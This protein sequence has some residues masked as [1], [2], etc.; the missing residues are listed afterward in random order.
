MVLTYFE[1]LP[2][3]QTEY[4]FSSL[5]ENSFRQL[6]LSLREVTLTPGDLL[7]PPAQ[8][9]PSI[10]I[11][12]SGEIELFLSFGGKEKGFCKISKGGV[13]REKGF[14]TG[15]G[16]EEGGRS[17]GFSKVMEVDR[18]KFLEIIKNN[19]RDFERFCAAKEN[20]VFATKMVLTDQRC[21]GCGEGG[22]LV[23][24]CK[25][26]SLNIRK[27][28]VIARHCWDSGQKRTVWGRKRKKLNCLKMRKKCRDGVKDLRGE[29]FSEEEEEEQEQEQEDEEEEFEES[30]EEKQNLKKLEKINSIENSREYRILNNQGSFSN[31]R[32]FSKEIDREKPK[33]RSMIFSPWN[34]QS[35]GTIAMLPL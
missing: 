6:T 18:D 20:T 17:L 26:S 10:Y 11:I 3:A 14:I 22:H 35:S 9:S 23:W 33:G 29:L 25:W 24:E 8:A 30:I 7:F 4:F 31:D 21:E 32:R 34:K 28:G 5:S 1:S 2:G 13:L 12:L 16:G 19:S 27:Q 15:V